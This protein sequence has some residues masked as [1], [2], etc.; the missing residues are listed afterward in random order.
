[1]YGAPPPA[2]GGF[3]G[4]PGGYGGGYG[5]G[6]GYGMNDYPVESSAVITDYS[7]PQ[8]THSS[9]V[10]DY[11]AGDA[12][13]EL[14]ATLAALAIPTSDYSMGT[15]A[16]PGADPFASVAGGGGGG[17]A[18]VKCYFIRANGTK[19]VSRLGVS[20]FKS[21]QEVIRGV[22][23]TFNRTSGRVT[24][25]DQDN[26]EIEI[27]AGTDFDDIVSFAKGLTLYER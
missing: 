18:K 22:Y 2:A 9:Y 16:G 7:V 3:Y 24:Y 27:S 10:V 26:D 13:A 19:E 21:A 12:N 20:T 23:S 25:T 4:N 6:A 5:G 1:M 14:E 17:A 8:Q 11:G 15:A